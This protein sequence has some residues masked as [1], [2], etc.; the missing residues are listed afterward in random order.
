MAITLNNFPKNFTPS[1]N[2]IMFAINSD[3]SD[4]VYF[5]AE[6]K[7]AVTSNTIATLHLECT[8]SNQTGAYINLSSI[9]NS[10]VGYEFTNYVDNYI[11]T[12]TKQILSYKVTFTEMYNNAGAITAGATLTT[13]IFN[14]FLSNLDTISYFNYTENTYVLTSG[15]LAKFMTAKPNNL[16]INYDSIEGLY[17]M[18]DAYKPTMKV[19][20]KAYNTSNTIIQTAT[21]P[22][23]TT[24]NKIIRINCSP[25][26]IFTEAQFNA[27]AYFTAQLFDNSNVALSEIRTYYV[28]QMPCSFKKLNVTWLN[29]QGGYDSYTFVNPE[30]TYSTTSRNTIQINNMKADSTGLIS[31]NN[32]G[33][34][35]QTTKQLSAP[36]ELSLKVNTRP[37]TDIEN[38]WLADLLQSPHVLL[39]VNDTVFI[40]ISI[41]E[42]N[43]VLTS[44]RY[45]KDTANI[46]QYT[47]QL[48]DGFNLLS[49]NIL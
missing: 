14:V 47:L 37:L 35:N 7:D 43:Q 30:P 46:K 25:K 42:N 5:T 31:D 39:Q 27:A 11:D 1:G 9:L 45:I 24:T 28:D 49:F 15:Q 20:F 17:F 10:Y 44:R 26:K 19:V 40:P 33:I 23:F 13:D 48:P 4:I 32:A 41:T 22:T 3:N 8:P 16:K 34:F 18:Q 21:T 6:V 36:T 38:Y 12:Y 2:A 29:R